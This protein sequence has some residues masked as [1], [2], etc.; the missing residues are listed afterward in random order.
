MAHFIISNDHMSGL[1]LSWTMLLWTS[2]GIYH[3]ASSDGGWS[4]DVFDGSH[5]HLTPDGDKL[6]G[7]AQL[8]CRGVW[9]SPHIVSR[10]LP[11]VC[12]GYWDFL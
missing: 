4:W 5:A 11:S 9:L 7:W 12:E 1:G 6:K 3:E 2:L 10:P 8:C